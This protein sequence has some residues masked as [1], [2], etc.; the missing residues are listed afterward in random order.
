M[1]ARRPRSLGAGLSDELEDV[2]ALVVGQV[3][4]LREGSDHLLRGLGFAL[5]SN[6]E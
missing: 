4:S 3:E 1:T 5:P 2:V 6:H